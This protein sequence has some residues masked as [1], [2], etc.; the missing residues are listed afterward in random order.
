[1]TFI[2]SI[3]RFILHKNY[4]IS[5]LLTINLIIF[6]ACGGDGTKSEN[7]TPS[8]IELSTI[9]KLLPPSDNGIYFGAFPDFGGSED[10]IS[11]KR[12]DDFE[13][14]IDKKIVWA[15][16][17]NNW[18]NGILYPKNDIHTIYNHGSIPFVRLMP[19]SDDEQGKMETK[20][21]LQKIIDG[22]F[23][24]ELKKWAKDAK[25]D[26]IP[27]LIDFAVEMNGDWFGW[28]GVY[29][30]GAER[31]RDAYRHIIDIFREKGADNI[32]WFFH[33]DINTMP[34][35]KW[36]EPKYYY[37]GDD[38]IDWIGISIY[39]V[40]DLTEDFDELYF[41][42][43]LKDN[44]KKITAISS[45]KPIAILEFGVIDNGNKKAWLEDAFDT[46]LDNPYIDFK[47]ISY[48]HE[49]WENEDESI[50]NLRIDSS[51]SSLTTFKNLIKN[52][53]FINEL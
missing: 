18:Y 14:L 44:Y 9:K 26:N 1:M 15:Y 37:P 47:A 50:S 2:I 35:A 20:F 4:S 52:P 36:N 33:P 12:I 29:N 24:K 46:I 43:T 11:K 51:P 53:R 28:S 5:L 19:R 41:S 49:N 25:E 34:D 48:W 27:L 22:K 39:G 17:S 3:R 38:Y 6:I 32:T 45:T 30:G 10:H 21:S 8:N 40:Q 31:Y 13:K 7:N 42:Q 16:F 23:D